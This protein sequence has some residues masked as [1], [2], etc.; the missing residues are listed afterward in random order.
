[1]SYSMEEK[2][3]AREILIKISSDKIQQHIS[4]IFAFIAGLYSIYQIFPD[5]IILRNDL[6]IPFISLCFLVFLFGRFLYW[7]DF[8]GFV[9]IVSPSKI[10]INDERF[11]KNA[12]W[13]IQNSAGNRI[14]GIKE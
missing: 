11:D 12:I 2:L 5:N 9:M 3:K 6:I 14:M 8:N 4:Y 1:M 7:S 10:D 13:A